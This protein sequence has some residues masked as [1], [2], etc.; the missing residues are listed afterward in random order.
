MAELRIIDHEAF[1][2]K[3]ANSDQES[4]WDGFRFGVP[5]KYAGYMTDF[6]TYATGEWTVTETQAGAT[7]ALSDGI[8]G[9]LLLTNSAADN[10]IVGLQ[11][12]SESFMPTAGKNIYFEI[13]FQTN[14]AEQID[15]VAGLCKLQNTLPTTAC[16][17]GVYFRK[18]DGDAYIDC[19][20]TDTSVTSAEVAMATQLDATNVVLG[21]R[22]VGNDHV[23]FW[24]NGV[25]KCTLKT[26]IPTEELSLTFAMANGEA[27]AKTATI[28][29]ICAYQER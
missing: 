28:D 4:M 17:D 21:L 29:Y 15:W 5:N 23:D 20:A 2:V 22:V 18:D 8:L 19:V 27:V 6:L 3:R 16:T 26:V 13:K 9:K 25:K 7:Q 10:D 14:L 12:V 24:I 1:E 11:L